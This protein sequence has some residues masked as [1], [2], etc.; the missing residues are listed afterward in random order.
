VPRAQKG[1][2]A[3]RL[4]AQDRKK[5]ARAARHREN[6]GQVAQQKERRRAKI[7]ACANARDATGPDRWHRDA[8]IAPVLAWL[9]D[10]Q[11][12]ITTAL[13]QADGSGRFDATLDTRGRR[14]RR[15]Q[16]AARGR[17]VRAGRR[18][19]FARDGRPIASIGDR[20][21]PELAGAA[22]EATGVSL[23][24]HPRNPYV[25]TS[26]ANV[27]C[28]VATAAR[29]RRSRGGSAAGST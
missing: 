18:Q 6:I 10:L 7:A 11:D 3:A 23:V 1:G 12:R 9:R 5:K 17:R 4:C 8:D 28:L 16:S 13:E 25:P 19:F 20:A 15:E 24:I 29:R 14:W 22:F 2:L 21:T 26:H 27:R